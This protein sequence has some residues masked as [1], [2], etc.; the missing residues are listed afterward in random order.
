VRAPAPLT[1]PGRSVTSRGVIALMVW[2][3]L[4]ALVLHN[5]SGELRAAVSHFQVVKAGAEEHL[6]NRIV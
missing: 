1:I 3:G 2:L 6:D 5:E 4:T